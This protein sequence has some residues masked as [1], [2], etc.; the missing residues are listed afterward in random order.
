MKIIVFNRIILFF[1]VF[2]ASKKHF[3]G[4]VCGKMHLNEK[5]AVRPQ[6]TC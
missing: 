6:F 3:Y 5:K 1:I 2:G 4:A